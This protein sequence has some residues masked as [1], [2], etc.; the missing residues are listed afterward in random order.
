MFGGS[1]GLKH[2]F[3]RKPDGTYALID[4][5][6]A[7]GETWATALNNRGQIVVNGMVLNPDGSTAA[8]DPTLNAAATAIDDN[9]RLVG[10]TNSGAGCRGFMAV[11]A[12]GTGPLIRPARGVIS[13]SGYGGFETIAPGSWIEIYG[14]NLARTRRQWQASDFNGN[15]APTSLDGVKVTIN[16]RPAFVSY[17]SPGQV[18]AQVPSTLTPGPAQ[19][20]VTSGTQT[21]PGYRTT[22]TAAKP[23]LL[24]I[25][26]NVADRYALALFP[27]FATF[28]LPPLVNPSIPPLPAVPSRPAKPGETIIFYGIGF[29]SV[30]PDVPAGRIATD[31]NR[32]QSQLEVL[33]NGVPAQVNYAGQAPGSV[34][35]YQFNVV[36]PDGVEPPG[37]AAYSVVAVEFRLNGDP[38]EQRLSTV[39]E[40]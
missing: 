7:A 27:D 21:S 14:S 26:V 18:N 37:Q 15:A 13:A 32:L 38:L 22:V 5:P 39:V 8:L 19:V 31:T 2:G 3:L 33:F 17:I 34:G 40:P 23:G 29:G 9:G 1:N 11:P 6:G 25:E 35:L 4:A 30:T 12:A 20:T 36:V 16:G 24:A 10:C 28:V